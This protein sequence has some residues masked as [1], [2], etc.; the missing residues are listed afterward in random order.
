[1]EKNELLKEIGFSEKFIKKIE[2]FE[3]DPSFD[4]EVQ[5]FDNENFEYKVQDTSTFFLKNSL[6]KDSDRIL[7]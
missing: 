2:E 1:M 5:S 7:T 3:K 4:I 6:R